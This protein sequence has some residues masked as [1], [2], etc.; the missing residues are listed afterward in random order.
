MLS[1]N[2]I[3]FIR[4]LQQKKF[5]EEHRL[6]VAEGDKLV[7]EMLNSGFTVQQVCGL[8][9]WIVD[10]HTHAMKAASSEVVKVMDMERMSSMTTAPEV[11]AVVEIPEY[12]ITAA[13]VNQGMVLMLDG[14]RDPGN[15]GTLIRTADWFGVR[16]I[17]AS[18]DSVEF[19][20]PK[21]IQA[22]MGSITR[23][24][25]HTSDLKVAVNLLRQNAA[26]NNG[27]FTVYG[28]AM[29]GTDVY[30]TQWSRSGALIIGNESNGMREAISQLPDVTVAIPR[31]E[32]SAAES[33][34]AGIAAG[35]LMNEYFRSNLKTL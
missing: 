25:L 19:W 6:F 24:R 22:T 16:D 9:T 12:D 11:L 33:L 5:R 26:L 14:I 17:I 35:I 7:R 4:S 2:R 15:M 30:K 8:E 1:N 20:N 34:N 10:N 13:G 21:V 18:E 29:E 32:H 23:V 3:S 31:A 27:D 28:A